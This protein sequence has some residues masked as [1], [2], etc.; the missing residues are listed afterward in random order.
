MNRL[1]Y[2]LFLVIFGLF[3]YLLAINIHSGPEPVDLLPADTVAVVET[4]ALSRILAPWRQ[5]IL[6]MDVTDLH[7]Q[8]SD[9][10]A[11]AGAA[12]LMDALQPVAALARQMTAAPF[13]EQLFAG[14]AVVA[15]LPDHT[16]R[17]FAAETVFANLV[18]L[19]DLH[20][21]FAARPLLQDFLGS[22]PPEVSVYQGKS[23]FHVPLACGGTLTIWQHRQILVIALDPAPVRRCIDGALDGMLRPHTS[24]LRL[25]REYQELKRKAGT[26]AD[27]FLYVN[28]AAVRGHVESAWL[29]E[30]F[31]EGM[32]PNHVAAFHRVETD[33]HR[34]TLVTSFRAEQV[35]ALMNAYQLS[36]PVPHPFADRLS[37]ENLLLF[38]TNWFSPRLLLELIP[39][40]Q[41][42]ESE[43]TGL[44]LD[45]RFAES[46]GKDGMA[47]DD[48]FGNQ[49]GGFIDQE[50]FAGSSQSVAGLFLEVR[51]RGSAEAVMQHILADLPVETVSTD[52]TEIVSLI[53]ANGLFQ[54]SYLL[55]DR[56]L[57]VADYP[58]LLQRWRVVMDREWLQTGIIEPLGNFFLTFQ[59]GKLIPEVH[60]ILS[61]FVKKAEDRPSILSARDRLL[62]R[63]LVMPLLSVLQPTEVC[64]LRA[65]VDGGEILVEMNWIPSHVNSQ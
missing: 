21:D 29:G 55:M 36:A 37:A 53:M 23:L 3:A 35:T 24:G 58:D 59:S 63:Y 49:F 48:I 42:F 47:F 50:S 34:L 11:F 62:L 46:S 10:K 51:D 25:N 20:N 64:T 43:A 65:S 27:F 41:R 54:P 15:L 30:R 22:G 56:V 8:L 14:K 1:V 2:L 40:S 61:A 28:L 4:T 18:L 44:F 13:V 60:S 31:P 33:M 12:T 6:K 19:V 26:Q 38:W 39:E 16:K 5:D 57:L 45:R 32:H 7:D 52:D 17:P 9:L